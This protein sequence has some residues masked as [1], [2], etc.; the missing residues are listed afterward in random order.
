MPSVRIRRASKLVHYSSLRDGGNSHDEPSNSRGQRSGSIAQRSVNDPAKGSFLAPG[1]N[2]TSDA[3]SLVYRA[4][5][6]NS[7]SYRSRTSSAQREKGALHTLGGSYTTGI[8]PSVREIFKTSED[9]GARVPPPISRRRAPSDAENQHTH[10]MEE[11]ESSGEADVSL[12]DDVVVDHLDIV[13]ELNSVESAL[14][15]C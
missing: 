14:I 2:N 1:R 6:H 13:G 4:A 12:H 11:I 5:R 8:R 15:L 7:L 9:A 3:A 10:L